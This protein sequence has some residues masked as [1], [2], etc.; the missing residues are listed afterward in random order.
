M[1]S[2]SV[3]AQVMMSAML[4]LACQPRIDLSFVPIM[5]RV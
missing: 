5:V 1:I 2:R 3:T 4:V